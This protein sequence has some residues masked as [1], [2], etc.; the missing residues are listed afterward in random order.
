M[1]DL[2]KIMEGVDALR[3]ENK[4]GLTYQDYLRVLLMM[5][6]SDVKTS[7]CMD[8]MEMTLRE[9]PGKENFHLDCCLYTVGIQMNFETT[10][11]RFYTVQRN[12]GYDMGI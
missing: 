12:Y 6:S 9:I 5:K 8:M 7:R 1:T 3:K 4:E 2:P 11:G 10:R